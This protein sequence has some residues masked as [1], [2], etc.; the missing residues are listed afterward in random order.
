[1]VYTDKKIISDIFESSSKREKVFA[2]IFKKLSKTI[3]SMIIRGGGTA[4]D[5][6]EVLQDAIVAFWEKIHKGKITTMSNMNVMGYIT[7]TCKYKWADN[8]RKNH[9]NMKTSIDENILKEKE[10]MHTNYELDNNS[11]NKIEFLLNQIG[12]RCKKVIV[13]TMLY[14]WPAEEVAEVFGYANARSV[15]TRKHR[16]LKQLFELAKN[17]K[18]SKI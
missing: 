12:K 15:I 1:M 3:K 17:T 14:K 10:D 13:H 2:Y 11:K 6:E 16:C 18:K 8:F 4:D 5:A 9:H 7:N